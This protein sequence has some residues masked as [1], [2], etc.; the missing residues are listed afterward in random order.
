MSTLKADAVT[1]ATGTNTDL[2][3]AGKG[4]GVP[5]L[6]AGY[7]VNGT[8]EK[9]T[10][11]APGSSGNLLTSDGTDWTSAAAD[12]VPSGSIIDYAGTSAPSGWRLCDGA[13]YNSVADTT[14]AALF[15]AIG[16]LYGGS[17]STD[18]QVPDLRGR[19]V[20]GQDDMGGSSA[21]RI[22]E[23]DAHG[24]NGDTLG[25][26][27]GVGEHQLTTAELASHSHSYGGSNAS[28]TSSG[29]TRDALNF[30]VYNSGSTGSDDAHTNLQPSMILNKIIKK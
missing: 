1:A 16:N 30:G 17:G 22:V 7:K 15:T 23:T 24:L 4:T 14:F 6:A 19:V 27:G 3:L 26:V 12:A 21:N 25:A 18:F 8:V 2:T 28:P 20:V 5:D 13:A 10:G 9:L 29:G 11:I